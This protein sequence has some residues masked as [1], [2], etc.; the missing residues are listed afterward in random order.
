MHWDELCLNQ[1]SLFQYLIAF[2]NAILS[3]AALFESLSN[4]WS[5]DELMVGIDQLNILLRLIVITG[6]QVLVQ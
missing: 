2:V 3:R 1:L 4:S 6:V 5:R